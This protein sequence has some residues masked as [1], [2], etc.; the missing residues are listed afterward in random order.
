M[1]LL[2]ESVGI[3]GVCFP[4][5]QIS[6]ILAMKSPSP[7]PLFSSRISWWGEVYNSWSCIAL[8]GKDSPLLQPEDFGVFSVCQNFRALGD[9]LC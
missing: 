2:L 4:V 3:S 6:R 8:L 7:V 1:Q 9:E 5:T